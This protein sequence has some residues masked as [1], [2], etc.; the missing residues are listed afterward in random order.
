MA[1]SLMMN[2]NIPMNF[3]NISWDIYS[4]LFEMDDTYNERLNALRSAQRLE[5]IYSKTQYQL[6][7]KLIVK[8]NRSNKSKGIT[9]EYNITITSRPY[10]ETINIMCFDL[11]PSNFD[12][13]EWH[14]CVYEHPYSVFTPAVADDEYIKNAPHISSSL[15]IYYDTENYFEEDDDE[16]DDDYTI[17][18]LDASDQV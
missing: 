6:I 11:M 12:A 3:G 4:K 18:I 5:D 7:Y 9:N 2:S 10:S 13:K 17:D 15:S 1:Q 16:D 14:G 8:L